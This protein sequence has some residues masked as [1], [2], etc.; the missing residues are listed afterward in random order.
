MDAHARE[1]VLAV[2]T[3]TVL[4]LATDF[5]M[6]LRDLLCRL[7]EKH[8]LVATL[9]RAPGDSPVVREK[10]AVLSERFSHSRAVVAELATDLP[11]L[12]GARVLDI[13]TGVGGMALAFASVG[14]DVVALDVDTAYLRVAREF[15]SGARES[16]RARGVPLGDLLLAQ[17]SGEALALPDAAF[18]LAVC[19]DILEH[20]PDPVRALGE[21]YRV[22]R[23]GG[24]VL[25][26]QGFAL[27]PDFIRRDPHYGLPLVVLLPRFIRHAVVVRLAQRCA[28]LRDERWPFTH[29]HLRRWLERTG[30]YRTVR[31]QPAPVSLGWAAPLA[32]RAA[33]ST[34]VLE[35]V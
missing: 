1:P 17:M 16:A 32:R 30:T 5:A 3:N 26:R 23:P 15:F 19:S 22:L 24:R 14:A 34:I 21:V 33:D 9:V 13:G 27:N 8:R 7:V 35:K 31:W 2:G 29:G 12:A 10:T 20:V 18:D 4:P 11:P 28:R 6:D 25:I